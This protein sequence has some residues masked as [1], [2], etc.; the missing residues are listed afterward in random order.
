MRFFYQSVFNYSCFLSYFHDENNV[1]S[2]LICPDKS[3]NFSGSLSISR[4]FFK[5]KDLLKLTIE[6]FI[7]PCGILIQIKKGHCLWIQ[8]FIFSSLETSFLGNSIF[9]PVLLYFGHEN[10]NFEVTP[11]C[12]TRVE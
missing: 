4:V 6:T 10:S 12:F 8:N 1:L 3:A 5:A 11:C 7:R 2:Y 9:S